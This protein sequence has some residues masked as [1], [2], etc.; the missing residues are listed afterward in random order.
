M[1]KC[2]YL[3]VL[4]LHQCLSFSLA[5]V[6]IQ[7]ATKPPVCNSSNNSLNITTC[8]MQQTS[9]GSKEGEKLVVRVEMPFPVGDWQSVRSSPHVWGLSFHLPL[10]WCCFQTWH[11]IEPSNLQGPPEWTT[12]GPPELWSHPVELP[13]ENRI[14]AW[15]YWALQPGFTTYTRQARDA[16]QIGFAKQGTLDA[17]WLVT[18]SGTAKMR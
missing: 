5:G 1:E 7:P 18:C 8:E 3:A 12:P 11:I 9:P 13:V 2:K 4:F 14:E 17:S 6:F 10:D 15:K 16:V